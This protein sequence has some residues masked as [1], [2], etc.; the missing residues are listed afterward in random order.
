MQAAQLGL[1][2]K[3]S[4]KLTIRGNPSGNQNR[5]RR[6]L[7]GGSEGSPDQIGHHSILK[8]GH[9]IQRR[10]RAERQ[11]HLRLPLP[12]LKRELTRFHFRP[13]LR[14]ATKIVENRGLDPAETEIVGISFHSR[15][16]EAHCFRISM[17]RKRIDHG[18][19][20]IPEHEHFRHFVVRFPGGI[21][22]RPS[23]ARIAELLRA[24]RAGR[25]PALH[26]I[27]Q[28]VSA[29]DNQA[30]RGKFG[31]TPRCL[32]FQQHRVDMPFQVIHC[33]ERLSKRLRQH[34]AIRQA[35]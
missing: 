7:F 18:P 17:G 20:G 30:Q 19:A 28:R 6:E 10:L 26:R 13:E 21:V 29:R 3:S 27:E 14:A 24:I 8:A 15:P 4:A 12:A 16:P 23:D 1:F 35:H 11:Q 33:D 2:L 22:A 9:E 25:L 32:G 31:S 5:S 34:F